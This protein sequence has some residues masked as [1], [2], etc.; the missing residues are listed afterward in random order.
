MK[1]LDQALC[2]L[3]RFSADAPLLGVRELS[4]STGISSS[5]VQRMLATF[6]QHGFVQQCPQTRKYRL[7][8]RLWELGLLFR[9]QFQL[10]DVLQDLLQAAAE[11]TGETVYL[12]MLE[13]DE[14][15][16]VQIAES[17]ESVKVAIRL[18]E[19]TPLH[20]GSRGRVMLAFLPPPRRAAILNAALAGMPPEEAAAR[21]EGIEASLAEV[22]AKGWCQSNGERLDG[23]VGL[24]GPIFDLQEKVIASVTVGGPATRMTK[25]KVER[26]RASVL[27]LAHELQAHFR[28]FG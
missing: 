23:V 9:Q 24:S 13:G 15:L 27:A 10:G 28:N 4:A 25:A 11:T 1:S 7:G 6:Q 14:A 19:R 22:R 26:C 8:S 16:C 17:P 5:A 3:A 18:G 2:L 21:S 20:A 12:N